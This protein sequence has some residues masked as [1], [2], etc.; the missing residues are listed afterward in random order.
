[1]KLLKLASEKLRKL[2]P[3]TDNMVIINAWIGGLAVQ[4]PLEYWTRNP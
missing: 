1:M 4:T 3:I 2:T